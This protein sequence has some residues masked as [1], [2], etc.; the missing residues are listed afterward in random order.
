MAHLSLKHSD[1]K[2]KEGASAAS[3]ETKE[4]EK[5]KEAKVEEDESQIDA[6][7]PF[8]PFGVGTCAL[9]HEKLSLVNKPLGKE[10]ALLFH[11]PPFRSLHLLT[12]TRKFSF[13]HLLS[14]I[15]PSNFSIYLSIHLIYQSI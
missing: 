11:I 1:E 3:K 14:S 10:D 6:S 9:C 7:N 8:L 4:E 2:K 15:Y 12:H 5:E 13:S